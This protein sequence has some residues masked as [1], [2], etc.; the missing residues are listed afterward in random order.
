MSNDDTK[1]KHSKR[2]QKT[3]RVIAKRERL[4]KAYKL[5]NN[6]PRQGGGHRLSKMN[7]INCGNPK[8]FMCAN[9]RKMFKERTIKEKSFDQTRKWDQE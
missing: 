4:R 9:P 2:R 8:C 1:F 5:P 6:S 3:D 7:G